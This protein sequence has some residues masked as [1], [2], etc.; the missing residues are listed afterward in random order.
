MDLLADLLFDTSGAAVGDGSFG[1]PH[2]IAERFPQIRGRRLALRLPHDPRL[3]GGGYL[4]IAGEPI[5][6]GIHAS[7]EGLGI[8]LHRPIGTFLRQYLGTLTSE[9]ATL[10]M[11]ATAH[12]Q[13]A[14]PADFRNK[15]SGPNF[16]QSIFDISM[17]VAPHERGRLVTVTVRRFG[18]ALFKPQ[19]ASDLVQDD[20]PFGASILINWSNLHALFGARSEHSQTYPRRPFEQGDHTSLD[21]LNARRAL[22]GVPT[23]MHEHWDKGVGVCGWGGDH[24]YQLWRGWGA[25][26]APRICSYGRRADGLVAPDNEHIGFAI[27]ITLEEV[28]RLLHAKPR[29]EI[30][31]ASRCGNIGEST[32]VAGPASADLGSRRRNIEE[33]TGELNLTREGLRMRFE[34][35]V[36]D[37]LPKTVH[38]DPPSEPGRAVSNFDYLVPWESLFLAGLGFDYQRRERLIP[39]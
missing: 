26:L 8:T 33:L 31:L 30:H 5:A 16:A 14:T 3:E 15:E 25:Q 2:R 35:R 20:E 23:I 27:P 22:A 18:P 12:E 37:Y 36:G 32:G 1:V 13:F 10:R 17:T 7:A 21:K 29:A 11:S 24:A 4:G 34:V 39:R 19:P 38:G 28:Q 6:P 9:E